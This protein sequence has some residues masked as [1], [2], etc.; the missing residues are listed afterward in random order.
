VKVISQLG[1]TSIQPVQGTR[2]LL[3]KI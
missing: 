1:V 2:P 3:Y